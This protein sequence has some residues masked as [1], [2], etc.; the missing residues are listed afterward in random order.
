MVHTIPSGLVMILSSVPVEET[1]TRSESC[2]DQQIDSHRFA[3]AATRGVQSTPLSLV[4]T[5]TVPVRAT[6]TKSSSSCDHVMSIHSED[7]A[8]G[9]VRNVQEIPSGLVMHLCVAGPG[10]S[11]TAAYKD[12]LGDQA[13]A[14]HCCCYRVAV[15]VH[16]MPSVLRTERLP[17]CALLM[18]TNS[19]R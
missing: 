17:G 6:A 5:W 1:Q 7:A 13:I 9:V 3:E 19:L 14:R 8:P 16:T 10:P 12:S 18:P 15:S 4:M 11:D 2:G